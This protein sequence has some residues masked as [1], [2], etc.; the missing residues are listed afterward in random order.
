M[1]RTLRKQKLQGRVVT[2]K[3]KYA[4]FRTI[5]R[6]V[7]LEAPVCATESIYET[8][9]DLLDHVRLEGKVRLIGL[10]VSG[11]DNQPRQLSLP[12]GTKADPDREKRRAKLD[13]IM[14]ELQNKFGK[15]SVVRGRLFQPP[16]KSNPQS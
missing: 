16:D 3:I 8:A 6:R 7:T 5:T 4:D 10:G 12:F 2:L 11:F 13:H 14:D 15:T 1:G 9:C